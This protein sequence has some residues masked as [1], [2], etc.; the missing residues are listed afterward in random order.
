MN[1][2][3]SFAPGAKG[4]LLSFVLTLTL[5]SA[6][7]A[8]AD[9]LVTKEE[10]AKGWIS[11][12]DGESTF[13][14][15]SIGDTQWKVEGGKLTCDTGTGGWLASTAQFGDF[16][17]SAK[18]RAMG[19]NS[20]GI[21]V[22]GALVG[23][24]DENGS[25]VIPIAQAKG[26]EAW[27]EVKVTATGDKITATL[28]GKPVEGLKAGR[29]VGYIGIEFHTSQK[30]PKN[31]IEVADFRLMP[32]SLKPI[33]N[34]KDLSEWSVIPGKK[35]VFSVVDGAINIKD[36]NGQIETKGTYQNFALQLDIFSN[37][38]HLNSGVF[39][40]SPPGVFW[41]GYECQVR[42]QWAGDDRN[43]AV[44]FGTGGNYGNQPARRVVSSDREWFKMTIVVSD[45]NHASVYVNGFLASDYTDTRPVVADKDGKVGYVPGPGTINLQ[46][47]DPTTD[48]S[49][50]NIALQEY[51]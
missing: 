2:K 23:H 40:H 22:R 16:E 43:K 29:K 18:L 38:D 24:P 20:T 50:K 10:A 5:G 25:A 13:G 7:A 42:N 28:D 26:D 27:H 46:G 51:K 3:S 12:F 41:K 32:K 45:G 19:G 8:R 34:G 6:L 14:W 37:G 39:F 1:R 47:H 30:M 31:K 11:L 49:F 44:D 15:N 36:G 33:F 21:I 17:L 9:G 35:S 48:L 4:A